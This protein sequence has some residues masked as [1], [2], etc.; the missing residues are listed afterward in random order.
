IKIDIG[1]ILYS[2]LVTRLTNKSR[3]KYVSYPRFVS[4]SLAVLLGSDYTQ[5]ESFGSSPT[6]LNPEINKQLAGTGLPS[7]QLDEGTRKSQLLLEGTTTDP[8]DSGGNIQSADKRLPST[9]SNEG[10]V[11]TMLL[12]EGS[13]GDKD[14]EGFKQPTGMEPL[15]TLVADPSRTDAKY[16]ADHT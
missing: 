4:C 14:S 13:H 16:Q 12:P 3:Q 1:E 9:V 7:T 5:D 8:K 6:I 10:T 15:T 2:D 11:K